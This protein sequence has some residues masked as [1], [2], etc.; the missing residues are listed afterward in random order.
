[1]EFDVSEEFDWF[2]ILVEWELMSGSF[3]F[4]YKQSGSVSSK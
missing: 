1:M 2:S 4:I 3:V